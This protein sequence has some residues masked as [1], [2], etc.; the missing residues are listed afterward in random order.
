MIKL[1]KPCADRLTATMEEG[2]MNYDLPAELLVESDGPVRVVTLNNPDQL[3]AFVDP[4]HDAMVG[5]WAQLAADPGCRAVVLTGAGRA[6]SAG[7]N[8]PGFI[9]DYEDPEHRRASLRA[10]RKLVDEILGFPIPV[11]AAVNGPAV[12]LGCSLASLCDL[13]LIS[14][15]AYLADTHVSI[16]LVAGDG[17]AMSW[18]LMMSILKAK[19][20]LFTGDRILAAEA[21]SLGLANRMVPAD[22]LADEARALAQRIAAQPPQALQETKRALNLHLQQAAGL[23]LPF[24]LAAE[25]ESFGTDD[26]RKTIERFRS[27]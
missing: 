23:V 18:P 13:V 6:F 27:R 9:R 4:L 10:A 25:G 12:G 14:E 8:I 1:N 19:E 20:Y 15:D 2:H 22:R 26:I 16:G 5:I 21:V 7:G 24:A 3:N 11:I 17:G